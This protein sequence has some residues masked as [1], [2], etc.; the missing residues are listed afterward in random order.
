MKKISSILAI[1]LLIA[2]L[3]TGCQ[4]GGNSGVSTSQSTTTKPQ[5]STSTT[6]SLTK[7]DDHVD[8][9]KDALCDKCGAEFKEDP[10]PVELRETTL[11]LVG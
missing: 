2:M 6:P 3:I 5:A 8:E 10:V 11:Y 1:L 7:C 9:N 4:F